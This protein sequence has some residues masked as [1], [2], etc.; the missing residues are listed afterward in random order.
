[1]IKLSVEEKVEIILIYGEAGRNIAQAIRL[2][3]QRHPNRR[4]PSRHSFDFTVNQFITNG[5]VQVPKRTRPKTTTHQENEINIIAAVTHNPHISTRELE[6][7]SGISRTSILRILKVQKFHPYHI[8]LNQELH[9]DDFQNRMA[10]CTWARNQIELNNDFFMSV[11]FTDESSFTNRGMVNRHN[12]HYWSAENPHWMRQVEH[13]RQWSLNVWCGIIGGQ[14]IGPVFFEGMLTGLK[15]ANFLRDELPGL[16]EDVPL[17]HRFQ[18]FYQHD[19]CP[20]HFSQLARN[21]LDAE[22]PGRWIGRGGPIHWPARSPD[23]T[24]PD[25]FLWGDIKSKVYEDV[26]TTAENMKERI[27]AACNGISEETL[28]EVNNSFRRRIEKCI[29]VE[30]HQFE[31]LLHN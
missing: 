11:L 14:I 8:H 25:F 12:M 31:H 17:A 23:L 7:D 16:L 30:G 13:Q 10:F 24:K 20:A 21:V 4:V 6:R 5:T 26:P 2:Y 1:M 28:I 3:A 9:G 15:Y 22:F 27:R 19:G 18:M 29:E